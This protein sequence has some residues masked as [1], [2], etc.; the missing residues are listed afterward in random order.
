MAADGIILDRQRSRLGR[1]EEVV[2]QFDLIAGIVSAVAIAA[3]LW[4]AVAL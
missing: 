2:R 3:L 1:Q 4:V